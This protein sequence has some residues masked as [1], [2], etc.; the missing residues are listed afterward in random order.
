MRVAT[1]ALSLGISLGLG[2]RRNVLFI[3]PD[4]IRPSSLALAGPSITFFSIDGGGRADLPGI[5]LWTG[6]IQ[7]HAPPC[8]ADSGALAPRYR[9]RWSY[10]GSGTRLNWSRG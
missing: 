8:H 5:N 3:P 10:Y 1:D 6:S 2:G 9:G 4:D 7:E